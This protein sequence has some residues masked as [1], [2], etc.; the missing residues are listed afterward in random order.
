MHAGWHPKNWSWPPKH[1]CRHKR[2]ELGR[3]V[4]R[5]LDQH[6]EY[7]RDIEGDIL[8]QKAD[9]GDIRITL[10]WNQRRIAVFWRDS[11]KLSF[12]P[13][14]LTMIVEGS[15]LNDTLDDIRKLMILDD[16]AAI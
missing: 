7:V 12:M 11:I 13:S 5:L 9:V 3:R 10:W 14:G 6:S 8:Y 2:C 15:N 1:N 4:I 16:L